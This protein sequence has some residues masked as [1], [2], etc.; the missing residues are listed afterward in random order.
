MT[1]TE[2]IEQLQNEVEKGRIRYLDEL[3]RECEKYGLEPHEDILSPI[4]WNCCDRCGFLCP[5][6][7]LLWLDSLEWDESNPN[8]TMLQEG[9]ILEKE[10]YCA[11]CDSCVAELI[12]KGK[13]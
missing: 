8:D 5:S 1:S 13:K 2:R 9:M 12:K 7:Y 3:L 11:I 6:D 10:D 4:E